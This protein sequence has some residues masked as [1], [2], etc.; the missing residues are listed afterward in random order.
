MPTP[1]TP[2]TCAGCV[3]ARR[4]LK[5]SKPKTWCSRYKTLRNERCIDYRTIKRAVAAALNFWRAS[6]K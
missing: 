1:I 6:F 4:R 2:Q 5:W 3:H